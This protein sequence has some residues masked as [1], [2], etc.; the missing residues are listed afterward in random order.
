MGDEM[1]MPAVAGQFYQGTAEALRRQIENCYV[2]DLGPGALPEE[3][4]AEELTG[5]V[6]PHAGLMYSG[7]VAAHGY[8]ARGAS[9]LKGRTA[10]IVGPNHTGIGS[11]ISV[12]VEDFKTPLGVAHVDS[13][14]VEG[15]VAAGIAEDPSAHVYEHSVEV[16]IPFLQHLTADF[17]IV[18]IVMMAQDLQSARRLGRALR[19][20]PQEDLV[21]IAS[22]DL[23]HH[24][25]IE[26]ARAA[27]S[28]ALECILKGDP[29]SLFRTVTE[30]RISMCGFGPVMA[31]QMAIGDSDIR[32]L[33]YCTSGD[34]RPMR[35]VVGYASVLLKRS[36]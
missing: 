36:G 7:P 23:S 11:P 32:L 1:R 14:V 28:M 6:S 26:V 25:P 4:A 8:R 16:Q 30:K 29:E 20:L 35:D 12:S 19:E 17:K 10:V 15:L 21:Y 18:P 24:V 27:D 31:V 33:K 2:H 22:T 34:V 9:G 13:E 3:A 5:L